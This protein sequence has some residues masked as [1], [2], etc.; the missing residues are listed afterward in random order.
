MLPVIWALKFLLGTFVDKKGGDD[1][2]DEVMLARL[3]LIIHWAICGA[4]IAFMGWFFIAI[5][6]G[7]VGEFKHD[8][9]PDDPIAWVSLATVCIGPLALFTI[10]YWI[11][12]KRWAFFPWQHVKKD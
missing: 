9:L 8:G 1:P 7:R 10:L 2:K 5:I 4:V 11:V 3:A 6:E 12:T